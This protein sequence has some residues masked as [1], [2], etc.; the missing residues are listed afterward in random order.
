M[1]TWK[2]DEGRNIYGRKI[3]F[4]TFSCHGFSYPSLRSHVDSTGSRILEALRLRLPIEEFCLSLAIV[5]A[6]EAL[7]HG[8]LPLVEA[9]L[10]LSGSGGL[11]LDEV[12]F[13]GGI[14]LEIEEFELG[15]GSL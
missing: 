6:G 8:F 15:G 3:F 7:Q 5:R 1:D 14:G 13:F 9:G 11:L 4:L 12:V 2:P 10:Q